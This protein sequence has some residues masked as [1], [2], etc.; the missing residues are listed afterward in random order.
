MIYEVELLPKVIKWISKLPV[1]HQSSIDSLL[2][3]LKKHGHNLRLP[4]VKQVSEKVKELRDME[5]G[6]RIY[7]THRNTLVYIALIAGNKSTQ[8]KDIKLAVKLAKKLKT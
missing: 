8:S 7:Y 5:Y 3:M 2:L 6:Y 1:S 4:H